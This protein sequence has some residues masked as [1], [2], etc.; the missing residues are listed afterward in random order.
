VMISAIIRASVDRLFP[1][2]H[3]KSKGGGKVAHA[4]SLK[5]RLVLILTAS[6]SNTAQQGAPA[7]RFAVVKRRQNG[8]LS[9]AVSPAY[10]ISAL[11][12]FRQ[13]H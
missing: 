3:R 7:D 10:G 13:A 11:S 4:V 1:S 8:R 2:T 9:L 6:V 12:G 5:S